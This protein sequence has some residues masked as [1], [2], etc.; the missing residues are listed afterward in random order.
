MRFVAKKTIIWRFDKKKDP[1]IS[2]EGLNFKIFLPCSFMRYLTQDVKKYLENKK[3][4]LR[5]CL[6]M[7]IATTHPP[8][9]EEDLAEWVEFHRNHVCSAKYPTMASTHGPSSNLRFQEAL[10]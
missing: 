4:P 8:G 10:Y 7:D 2:P 9:W 3:M 6:L 1:S 5:C